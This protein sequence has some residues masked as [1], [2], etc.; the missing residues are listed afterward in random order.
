MPIREI[1][2]DIELP[3]PIEDF[4]VTKSEEGA[5]WLRDISS[6]RELTMAD[7]T[8]LES[9]QNRVIAGE[10]LHKVRVSNAYEEQVADMAA[11]A[12]ATRFQRD[13]TPEI[14]EDI[15][16]KRRCPA[17]LHLYTD[18]FGSEEL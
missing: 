4:L 3:T 16:N 18:D 1:E 6:K 7:I 10:V 13:Y 9:F 5:V 14:I 15:M 11:V 8:E 12:H 17:D 2:I